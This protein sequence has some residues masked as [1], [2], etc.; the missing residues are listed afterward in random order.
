MLFLVFACDGQDK[1]VRMFVPQGQGDYIE[2][3][4]GGAHNESAVDGQS[5][6]GGQGQHGQQS[7]QNQQ[8]GEQSGQNQQ[9][10]EQGQQ[11]GQQGSCRCR[12]NLDTQGKKNANEDAEE[13]E[14]ESDGGQSQGESKE[15]GSSKQSDS[16]SEDGS[17]EESKGKSKE[18]ES[19]GEGSKKESGQDSKKQA[20]TYMLEEFKI[21]DSDI[22]H[23]FEYFYIKL[24][25]D[26]VMTISYKESEKEPITIKTGYKL[27]DK[28]I[29]IDNM[30]SLVLSGLEIKMQEQKIMV[31]NKKHKVN[32][33]FMM[34]KKEEQNE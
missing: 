5:Q 29:I 15:Q 28:K 19:G 4:I 9:Q 6:G 20:G 8:Q 24:Q 17:K 23:I 25:K 16:K 12:Q 22:S 34:A 32:A 31:E 30:A 13:Q 10:G 7:G 14:K 11:Q 18:E 21:K 33:T 1:G 26:N 3:Q 2:Y 27:E